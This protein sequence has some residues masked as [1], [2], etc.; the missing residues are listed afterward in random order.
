MSQT[1]LDRAR[2]GDEQAFSELTEVYRGELQL[3]CYRI[4][5]S[6]EDAE[7]A[8]Q[9]ALLRAWRGLGTFAGRA[10]LRAWLY[11]IATRAALDTRPGR[12][13]RAAAATQT[14]TPP[15]PAPEP[16]WLSPLPDSLLDDTATGPEARYDARE[17]VSLAFLA[18]LQLL[19]PRQRAV[20]ILRDGLG[21]HAAEAADALDLSVAAANSALQRARA[22]MQLHRGI[23]AQGALAPASDARLTGLLTRYIAAWESADATGLVALL[24]EDAAYTMPPLPLWY[25]GTAAIRAFLAADVFTGQPAGHFRLIATQANGRPAFAVYTRNESG[26]YQLSALHVLDIADDQIAAIHAFLALSPQVL[27]TFGLF[28]TL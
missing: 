26:T 1:A 21:W 16:S 13:A 14:D 9:D 20:L 23:L 8:L 3:H 25:R 19:P 24:R 18:V 28:A 5:G 17:S 22:T 4:L 11:A 7:D 2:A 12:R 6:L 10:S 27:A 15:A